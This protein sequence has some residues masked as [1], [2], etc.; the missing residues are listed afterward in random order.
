[1]NCSFFTET[2]EILDYFLV[3]QLQKLKHSQTIVSFS[4]IRERPC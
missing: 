4:S 1:M 2:L 3:F